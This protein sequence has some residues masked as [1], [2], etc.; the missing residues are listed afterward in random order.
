M[1]YS[2]DKDNALWWNRVEIYRYGPLHVDSYIYCY[3]DALDFSVARSLA[4]VTKNAIFNF[5]KI[6]INNVFPLFDNTLY[7]YTFILSYG[8]DILKFLS[9]SDTKSI[10]YITDIVTKF[11]DTNYYYKF[12]SFD[13]LIDLFPDNTVSDLSQL[14]SWVDDVISNNAKAVADF[15]GGKT[16][17][18]NSL[19]GQVMKLSKGKANINAVGDILLN[20]LT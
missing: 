20:K 3:A 2:L 6:I 13:E 11:V 15:K 1:G 8:S 4:V 5:S 19:K 10:K 9:K 12:I 17:A 14:E 16:G 7:F 18:L